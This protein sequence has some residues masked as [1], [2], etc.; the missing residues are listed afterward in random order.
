MAVTEHIGY[1]AI[2]RKNPKNY[3]NKIYEGFK[4]FKKILKTKIRVEQ[5]Y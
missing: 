5:C 1:D 3:L 2:G 4:E